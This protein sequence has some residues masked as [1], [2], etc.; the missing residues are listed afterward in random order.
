MKNFIILLIT[1]FYCTIG[2]LADSADSMI[3]SLNSMPD[4]T[5][6]VR[7]LEQI[8]ESLIKK[9]KNFV[10]AES[11]IEIGLSL[12]KEINDVTG[13]V[14][15]TDLKGTILR[16]QSR[17]EDALTYHFSALEMANKANLNS[18]KV[19]IYN[20]IGVVHRR[21]DDFQTALDYHLRALKIAEAIKDEKSIAVSEN[22]I[23]NIY[24]SIKKYEKSLSHFHSALKIEEKFANPLGL[25]IN[26][27][28]I[29]AVYESLKQY[30]TA[31]EYYDKSL[32]Y[33]IEIKSEKGIAINYNSIGNVHRSLGN[34]QKALVYYKKAL[35]IDI[36]HDD[37]I[38]T[39]NSYINMGEIYYLMSDYSSAIE[40]LNKGISLAETIGSK[41]QIQIGHEHLCKVYSKL[42][43]YS[44]ALSCYQTSVLFKDSILNELNSKQMLDLQTKFDVQKNKTII[45][46]LEKDRKNQSII[47]TGSL[48]SLAL[49]SVLLF[50]LWKGYKIKK[51][52]HQVLQEKKDLVEKHND[53]LQTMNMKLNE[54]NSTKDKFFSIIAHDLKNPMQSLILSMDLLINFRDKLSADEIN[55]YMSKVNTTISSISSL[56]NNLLTWSRSQT[57]R[58]EFK[59]KPSNLWTLVDANMK[60]LSN[61][62]ENKNITLR[63]LL[64]KEFSADI[65][66]DMMSA[67][68]RNLLS[69]GIKFT[70]SGGFV[71]IGEYKESNSSFIAFYIK[72]SGIGMIPTVINR[73]FKIDENISTKDTSNEK[74]T[75]LG[76][77]IC[78]EF[79]EKHNGTISVESE[80]ELGSC[81]IVKLP[82]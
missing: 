52:A 1:F 11:Y 45:K 64:P 17:F 77:I 36:T 59:P 56:L 12:A 40:N 71:E 25:A 42:G 67:V 21:Q 78:K 39:S 79:V 14:S 23:G 5:S 60:L 41:Y 15:L 47:L 6:K 33:N 2:V 65:D 20:N 27:N 68:V 37:L 48:I 8:S 80:P 43:N 26:Y 66:N 28:N 72:D 4:D 24:I 49:L 10:K 75:G 54:L 35:A 82:K 50:F 29:G 3:R 74:G 13:M 61:S 31:L 22:S 30:N 9:E 62:A 38:Y 34:Y 19:K 81:F 55:S 70:N 51:Q 73:L 46:M 76:L 18:L 57:G 7:L 53:E 63:N 44:E 58:I 16:N 69:N 32:K